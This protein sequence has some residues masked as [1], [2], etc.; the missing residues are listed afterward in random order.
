MARGTLLLSLFILSLTSRVKVRFS[1]NDKVETLEE[2]KG[3][4]AKLQAELNSG[5]SNARQL[6]QQPTTSSSSKDRT[7]AAAALQHAPK[8]HHIK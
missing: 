7:A 3:Q 8:K 2:V 6:Q 4:L 1:F 5:L